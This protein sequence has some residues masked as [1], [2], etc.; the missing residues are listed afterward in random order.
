MIF[1]F[2]LLIIGLLIAGGVYG[3]RWLK[4][5]SEPKAI[6]EAQTL[7]N[8]LIAAGV[9]SKEIK[10]LVDILNE[11]I[12]K[13]AKI[14]EE[15]E[16]FD[17]DELLNQITDAEINDAPHAD[18]LKS[19]FRQFEDLE[20]TSGRLG[21]SIDAT[22]IELKNMQLGLL[23]ESA[24]SDNLEDARGKLRRQIKANR[25]VMQLLSKR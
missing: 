21:S 20:D 3:Y 6:S 5:S 24:G 7:A 4:R 22:L 18:S 23:N 19:Q 17:K 25:E 16:G 12:E 14:D 1:V 9:D 15:L 13:K 10:D 2:D 8:K 11:Q